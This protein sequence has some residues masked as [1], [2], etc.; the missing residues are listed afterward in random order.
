MEATRT[1][2]KEPSQ[3]NQ[4]AVLRATGLLETQAQQLLEDALLIASLNRLR[5]AAKVAAAGVFKLST[6]VVQHADQV[7]DKEKQAALKAQDAAA[8]TALMTLLPS[9]TNAVQAAGNLGTQHKLRETA[10]S[11]L[12]VFAALVAETK[13]ALEALPDATLRQELDLVSTETSS[14]LRLLAKAVQAVHLPPGA[15]WEEAM[16]L[17]DEVKADLRACSLLAAQG[18]LEA[19][20][21][22]RPQ[23][24]ATIALASQQLE[25]ALRSGQPLPVAAAWQEIASGIRTLAGSLVAAEQ[26]PLLEAAQKAHQATVALLE[27]QRCKLL[28]PKL[29]SQQAEGEW[30]NAM[31]A[32]TQAAQAALLSDLAA[33]QKVPSPSS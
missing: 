18:T 8:V 4:Q 17:L 14:A 21:A 15:A 3:A 31:A 32:L 10:R 33:A 30:K 6:A 25:Q 2:S 5:I 7:A 1:L 27:A 22:S 19:P 16:G 29:S 13:H 9:L 20:A 26:Q 11:E 24:Q 12:P 23:A 28:D